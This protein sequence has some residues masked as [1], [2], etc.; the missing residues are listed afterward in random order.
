MSHPMHR[1]Q[2]LLGLLLIRR[3]RRLAQ[4]ECSLP[5]NA[6]RTFVI[7][8]ALLGLAL[9]GGA[10]LFTLAYASLT[11]GLP[12][13]AILP[14]LLDT[15]NGLLLQPTQL[16]DRTGQALLYSLDLRPA[17]LR[18]FLPL[19]PYNTDGLS[20]VL[21][22]T[23]VATLDPSFWQNPG[24]DPG[25]LGS[26]APATIAERLVDQQLLD[27]EPAS[28]RRYLRRQLLAGQLIATFSR[29]QVLEW[30]LN[31]A[32]FGHLAYG[33]DSAARL[34]L[35]KP[36]SQL[37]LAESAL[38]A[39]VLS[40]PALNPLDSPI[41]AFEQQ[42]VVLDRLL[43]EGQISKDE[44]TLAAQE[45][46]SLRPA[47]PGPDLPGRAFI[48]LVLDDLN[49][50]F[51]RSR[52]EQ[53]GLKVITSLDLHLQGQLTCTLRTQLARLEGKTSIPI[54]PAGGETC[55]A[56]ALLPALPE[57]QAPL[58]PGLNASAVLLDPASGQILAFLGD[59]S[60][61]VENSQVTL[62]QPGT[63]LTPFVA[64]A[65]FARG[66]S[67]ASLVWD[68]PASPTAVSLN[69]DGKFRGPLRLRSALAN[70]I[71][72]PLNQVLLQIGAGS[73]WHLAEPLGLH[74]LSISTNPGGV[75]QSGGQASLVELA[76]AYSV[77]ASQ[78]SL[79]GYSTAPGAPIL[80]VVVLSVTDLQGRR[81]FEQGPPET[82]SVLSPQLAY[83][84]HNVLSDEPARW[85][86]L[87]YPNSLEIGR[88]AGAKVGLADSGRQVWAAG[89]TRQLTAVTW[90]GLP[91]EAILP[92]VKLDVKAA[93][94][95]WH[96][97]VQYTTRN[98]PS[99]DWDQPPGISTLDVCDP[100]G[101]LP[102]FTCPTLVREVF[103]NG[104][105]PTG[106]DNLYT[107]VEINRETGLL[108]TVFTPPELVEERVYMDLPPEAQAWG[109]LAGLPVPPADY[110][111]IQPP[112]PQPDVQ[113]SQPAL[114]AFVR[115]KI[116]LTGTAS[117]SGFASY[118]LQAGAGLNPTQWIE[119]GAG[120]TPLRGGRLGEWDTQG[121]NG[122]FAVRLQVVR[123]NQQV[124]TAVIQVSVDNTPPVVQI[125][126]PQPGERIPGVASSIVFQ[127][128][129]S[130][131]VGI[132]K[133]EYRLDGALVGSSDQPP[134]SLA[135]PALLPGEHTLVVT[136][137]D[138]AGNATESAPVAF[139]IE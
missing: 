10:L 60:A 137:Y 7:A 83:L 21:A 107:S 88:P 31:S 34:Y 104:N 85:P 93:A 112:I 99:T 64:V 1:R 39:G 138:L 33:A 32:Y 133:V 47:A 69:I 13:T 40:S 115:G 6:R 20:Q 82:R 18:R 126:S 118:R 22:Q 117:G 23:V 30:F 71:L 106:P 102:T 74:G 66:M 139:T 43:E 55:E 25:S 135:M 56:A 78:G 120:E 79:A 119:I 81:L 4:R 17:V 44:Y 53:G 9:A 111:R 24:F 103:L 131:N 116:T 80:P 67:P 59:T 122:L 113:I 62:H 108:A 76:Q 50:R 114:F 57:N 58:P 97:L 27:D 75:L 3:N 90:I 73:V 129:T 5:S 92:D 84:V 105:E 49:R 110:D 26:P 128:D 8:A 46:I 87:G 15:K 98:Q 14:A 61:G 136:V 51:G 42:R 109:R 70:D 94:G 95:L 130:D 134:Y 63:L 123:Q 125:S 38:L 2:Q 54:V 19:D 100:S 48:S 96:A 124:E 52:V 37:D 41:A 89:Y 29:Q 101:L 28:L 91:P 127:V 121:Q 11:T 35:D 65:A 36:A 86:S 16:Y 77:F 132:Q 12:S 45:A 68:V 72:A